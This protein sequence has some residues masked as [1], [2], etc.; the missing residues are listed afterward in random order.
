MVKARDLLSVPL[1]TPV[2]ASLKADARRLGEE[3]NE[4][5]GYRVPAVFTAERFDITEVEWW[6][7]TID[8][9]L[10]NGDAA[11]IRNAARMI[12]HYEDPG[13]G[14]FYDN[15]GWPSEPKHLTRGETLWGFMPFTGP[16]KRSHY[17]VA[18]TMGRPGAGVTFAYDGLDPSTQY[19]FRLSVGVHIEEGDENPLEGVQLKEGLVADESVVSEG[20]PVPLGD[21]RCF[22]FDIPRE[23][24]ED[25]SV[26][27]ALTAV[28]EVMPITGTNEAWLMRKDSML[29][30]APK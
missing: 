13:P 29:W 21:V 7:K 20:F 22:E 26:E 12:L 3:S 8:E 14:G 2:M 1:E 28:S 10:A 18:F 23:A 27:I 4:I 24:T 19:V 16:A 11:V 9:A 6:R 15:V 25:G 5:I 17:N 30:T